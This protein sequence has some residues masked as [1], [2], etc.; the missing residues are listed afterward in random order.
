MIHTETKETFLSYGELF[1]RSSRR[2]LAAER[3]VRSHIAGA[4]ARDTQAMTLVADAEHDLA[5][6]LAAYAESGMESIVCTRLQ[7]K[8]DT[9]MP[10]HPD[11]PEDALEN[12]T[13]IN[14][15]LADLLGDLAEKAAPETLRDNLKNLREVVEAVNRRISTIRLSTQDI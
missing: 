6:N 1:S 4:N 3:S 7:Y 2:C 8:L 13:S 5:M 9:A 11:N 12:V 14:I 15:D 10:A